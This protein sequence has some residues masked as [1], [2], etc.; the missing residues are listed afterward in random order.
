[1]FPPAVVCVCAECKVEPEESYSGDYIITQPG[2][3]VATSLSQGEAAEKFVGL[4]DIKGQRYR[5]KPVKL[6]HVRPFKIRDVRLKDFLDP[7]E[8]AMDQDAIEKV[9]ADVVRVCFLCHSTSFSTA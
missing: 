8:A 7:E 6:H 2:S 5:M 1:M 3:S 9:L 4:V